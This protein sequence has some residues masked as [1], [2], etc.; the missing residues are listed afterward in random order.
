[1]SKHLCYFRSPALYSVYSAILMERNHCF[2]SL[3]LM[4]ACKHCL[5]LCSPQIKQ[6]IY[7]SIHKVYCRRTRER[8][9]TRRHAQGA[10]GRRDQAK[11]CQDQ[12]NQRK[13]RI[14]SAVLLMRGREIERWGG[15]GWRA[16]R[17]WLVIQ[18]DA[19]T[20]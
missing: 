6:R 19:S 8:G 1:M 20:K 14:A 9:C 4:N 13:A 2:Q 10:R 12:R 5:S 18:D 17:I 3:N 16:E 15:G 11:A 7:N